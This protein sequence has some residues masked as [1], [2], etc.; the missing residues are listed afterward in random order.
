ME[1]RVE[2]PKAQ[3]HEC[4]DVSDLELAFV[5]GGIGDVILG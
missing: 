3:E 1:K 4:S 2:E 5:A